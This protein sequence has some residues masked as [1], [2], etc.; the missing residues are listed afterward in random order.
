[1]IHGKVTNVIFESGV[2]V[3]TVQLFD[4]VNNEVDAPVSRMNRSMF[5]IPEVGQNVQILKIDD[6]HFVVGVLATNTPDATPDLDEGEVC[7]QLDADTMVRFIKNGDNYDVD[8][9][10]SGEVRINATGD[11]KIDGIDFDQHTHDYG[12]S[13]ITD[14]G[15]GTGS[16]STT[17]KTTNPPQ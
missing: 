12:D 17:T 1:M 16:E 6:Q 7:I 10:A 2:P 4:R 15:D 14:T 8:I 13:T 9:D 11:V 5:M 3:C